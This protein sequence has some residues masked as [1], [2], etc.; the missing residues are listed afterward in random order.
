MSAI[1]TSATPQQNYTVRAIECFGG[2]DQKSKVEFD[3][4][5]QVAHELRAARCSSGWFPRCRAAALPM[6]SRQ[7]SCCERTQR[8]ERIHRLGSHQALAALGVE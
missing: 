4:D 3:R 6:Q 7:L 1:V 5:M 2:D 8:E